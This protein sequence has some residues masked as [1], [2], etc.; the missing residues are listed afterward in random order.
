MIALFLQDGS[1]RIA[2]PSHCARPGVWAQGWQHIGAV[3][4][5]GK[6]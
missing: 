3:P 2:S 4:G 6:R 5:R 1:G